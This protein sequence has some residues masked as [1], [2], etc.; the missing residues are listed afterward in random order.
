[1]KQEFPV[2]ITAHPSKPDRFV[3]RYSS[4]FLGATYAVDF[5]NTIT[6]AVALYHFIEMLKTRYPD[7]KVTFCLPPDA[8][9]HAVDAV[10]D[11][12]LMERLYK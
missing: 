1:M 3:A 8:P 2:Q 11:A 7:G 12:A 5:P 10:R 4:E 9:T 6:G